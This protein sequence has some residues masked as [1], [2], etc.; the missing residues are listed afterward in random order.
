MLFTDGEEGVYHRRP[1]CC[2]MAPGKEIVFA[3]EGNWSNGIFDQVVV[4]L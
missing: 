1:L 4:N 2:F 3:T